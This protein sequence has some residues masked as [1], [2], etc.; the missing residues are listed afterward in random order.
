MPPL[1]LD[2]DEAVA[3][4]VGL[5]TAAGASVTGIEE[6][7]VRALVKLEQVLPSHLRRRVNALQ[8]A[9]VTLAASGGPTVDPEALTAIAGACRDRERLRFA[10]RGR[11]AAETRR[12]VEPH[13][14]VNLGRRWYLVAWDCDRED[15]RTFRVDRLDAPVPGR[16]ALRRRASCP[17]PTPP[18]F[19]AANLSGAPSRY[20]AR[21]TLHAPAER[22]GRAPRSSPARPSRRSTTHTCELRTSDDSLDW[23]A[24][25]VA[26]LGVDFEVH[27]PPELV[28]RVRE[29][30]ARFGERRAPLD[31][32]TVPAV[33][34]GRVLPRVSVRERL[35]PR[36]QLLRRVCALVLSAGVSRHRGL[37]SAL[38]SQRVRCVSLRKGN[39]VSL[40]RWEPA[41]FLL[42]MRGRTGEQRN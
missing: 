23:L 18:A 4:A 32:V 25:R 9:T 34:G 26:M 16:H 42:V 11:D 6:T 21:V 38:A 14:L 22:G 20:Q 24:V 29:L 17:T 5:R 7:S 36:P 41:A 28:E 12:C 2:D 10:Y 35:P 19:V 15:W 1:L 13:T 8:T 39:R 33:G 3:I 40:C 30:A 31:A 37:A 27:E